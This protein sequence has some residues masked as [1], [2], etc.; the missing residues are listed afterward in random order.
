MVVP[1]L[2]KG[3]NLPVILN[4]DALATSLTLDELTV[5]LL[6]DTGRK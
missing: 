4:Y 6:H 1:L 5:M 3:C 2:I